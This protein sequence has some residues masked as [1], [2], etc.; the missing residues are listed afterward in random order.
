MQNP[1]ARKFATTLSV[2][3]LTALSI[4][5]FTNQA[6]AEYRDGVDG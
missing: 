4:L 3:S 2:A 1:F 6:K 5:P